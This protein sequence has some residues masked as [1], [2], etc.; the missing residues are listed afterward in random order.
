[1]NLKENWNLRRLCR[2]HFYSQSSMH[3]VGGE[4]N[5]SYGET[6]ELISNFSEYN[7]QPARPRNR[8]WA[9]S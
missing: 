3:L 5:G 9:W 8:G 7:A 4:Q 1:M 6:L 2:L